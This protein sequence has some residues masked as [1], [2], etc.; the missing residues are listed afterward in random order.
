MPESKQQRHIHT[1][2]EISEEE[3]WE[4]ESFGING[5][6]TTAAK[7][8]SRRYNLLPKSRS[9]MSLAAQK[10][11]ATSAAMDVPASESTAGNA[12]GHG[13]SK[14]SRRG[15]MARSLNIVGVRKKLGGGGYGGDD[16]DDDEEKPAGITPPHVITS[17]Q[18]TAMACSVMEGVGRTLKGRDLRNVRNAVW[19]HTGFYG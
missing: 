16:D 8:T 11:V 13:G 6:A 3:V 4:M 12:G 9:S 7:E 2:W 10:Y 5:T 14:G 18:R 17:R 1:D 19:K 15:E